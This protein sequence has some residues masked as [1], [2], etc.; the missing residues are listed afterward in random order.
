MKEIQRPCKIND[1]KTLHKEQKLAEA[2]DV[3]LTPLFKQKNIFL[4][5]DWW[6]E[7]NT[8]LLRFQT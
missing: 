1:T 5:N 7:Y 2:C 3:F 8:R 4:I 6:Y